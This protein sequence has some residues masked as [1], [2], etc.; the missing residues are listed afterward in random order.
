MIAAL[1]GLGMIMALLGSGAIADEIESRVRSEA[2][3][4]DEDDFDPADFGFGSGDDVDGGDPPAE[5]VDIVDSLGPITLLGTEVLVV[6]DD[7]TD[8]LAWEGD[9]TGVP[10]TEEF[11]E[12][13]ETQSGL[14]IED[15]DD[16]EAFIEAQI[17]GGP[18]DSVLFGSDNSEVLAGTDD[19]EIAVGFEGNDTIFFGSGD[20]VII[21]QFA[22]ESAGDDSIR[23]GR[24]EDTLVDHLGEDT[25]RGDG[26][27]DVIDGRDVPIDPGA[28]FLI[29]GT[30]NDTILG[31]G[32]DTIAGGP[33][34]DLIQIYVTEEA[35]DADAV[36][37]MDFNAAQ[38]AL[39][40]LIETDTPQRQSEYTLEF[41]DRFDT[42]GTTDV[43]VDGRLV[44]RLLGYDGTG[45]SAVVG[46]YRVS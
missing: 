40:I 42:A 44:A 15:R 30:G 46:N 8:P 33:G 2:D 9:G 37:I 21:A 35:T 10:S 24:G 28:D 43:R 38:D 29:G 17:T 31:D 14:D 20:D 45:A 3:D 7:G 5:P 34:G 23:G 27:S 41:V 19:N 25:I 32:A 13:Y 36:E 22:N 1:L 16:F 39:E 11:I 18:V 26:D 6:D 4:F 12:I